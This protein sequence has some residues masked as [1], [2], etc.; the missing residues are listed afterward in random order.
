MRLSKK[1]FT[2]LEILVVIVILAVVA[3][4]AI[5]VFTAN[6][7]K[8]K[9]QEAYASLAA[10]R[11]AMT[12]YYALNTS[13]YVGAKLTNIGYNPNTATSGQTINFSYSMA[14]P[15]DAAAYI[16]SASCTTCGA[17]GQAIAINQAGV[18]TV[19]GTTFA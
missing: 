16:V 14:D 9:A 6:V 17:T 18:T 8:S 3:G 19:T 11:S 2:L 10:V 4:L 15:V 13:T 1:G 5:P 7:Q 12:S